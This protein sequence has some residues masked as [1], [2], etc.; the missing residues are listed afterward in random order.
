MLT[1]KPLSSAGGSAGDIRKYLEGGEVKSDSI[2]YY[3]NKNGNASSTWIGAGAEMLGLEG[4]VDGKKVEELLDGKIEG[5]Q[6][7]A[8]GK[9]RRMGSDITFSA[10]KSVSIVA[11]GLEDRRVIEAHDEAVK[12]RS[13]VIDLS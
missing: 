12:E 1:I 2:K 3:E 10:P 11:L 7:T 9:N 6:L 4:A 13:R 8:D 5:Q